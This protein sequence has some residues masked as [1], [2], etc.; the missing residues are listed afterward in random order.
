MADCEKLE[1]YIRANK[2][3]I[4]FLKKSESEKMRIISLQIQYVLSK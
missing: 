1:F 3:T 4:E 2:E